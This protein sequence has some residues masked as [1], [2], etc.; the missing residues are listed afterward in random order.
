MGLPQNILNVARLH[1]RRKSIHEPNKFDLVHQTVSP[2]ERVGSGDKTTKI[3]ESD[4]LNRATSALPLSYD[5]RTTTMTC[6]AFPLL[7]MKA[8]GTHVVRS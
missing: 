5:Y 1:C 8:C 2:C 4:R 3:E 7:W 6:T